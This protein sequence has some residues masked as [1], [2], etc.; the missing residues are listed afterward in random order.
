[1]ADRTWRVLLIDDDD[2]DYVLTRSI[3]AEIKSPCIELEWAPTITEALE[4]LTHHPPDAALVDYHLGE[5]NGVEV[6]RQAI[7]MGTKTPLILLT[8]Y[9]SHAIDL[10]ASQ[11]GFVDYLTKS[12]INATLLERTLRYAIE[13][14]RLVV[15]NQ[16]QRELLQ[17]IFDL[18]P[19]CIA[20]LAGEELVFRLANPGYRA[21]TPHPEIDPTGLS[22][23]EVWPDSDGFQDPKLIREVLVSG[24]P[25]HIDQH[26]RQLPDGRRQYFTLHLQRL[27]W[28]GEKAVMLALWDTTSLVEARKKS[29]QN[30]LDHRRRAEELNAVICSMD[31]A[32]IIY[33]AQLVPQK[34]NP[35]LEEL[36]GYDPVLEGKDGITRRLNF[37][38]PDGKSVQLEDLPEG[39]VLRGER[40]GLVQ[41]HLTDARGRKHDVLIS[42]APLY[43]DDRLWGVVAVWHDI[44]PLVNAEMSLRARENNL[45]QA[46]KLA[47]LGYWTWESTDG[48]ITVSDELSDLFGIPRSKQVNLETY[49][50]AIVPE[51]RERIR[52]AISE[53]WNDDKPFDVEFCFHRPDGELRLAHAVMVTARDEFGRPVTSY[54]VLQD[55]TERHQAEEDARRNAVQIELHHMLMQ[56]REKERLAIARDLHDGPLQEVIAVNFA[57]QEIWDISAGMP[58]RVKVEAIRKSLQKHIRDLRAFCNELRPPALIP[59]G[60][61]KAIRSYVDGFREAHPELTLSLDLM[62]D[63]K[64][65]SEPIRLALFRIFQELLNNIVRHAQASQ[66]QVTLRLRKRSVELDVDDNGRGFIAPHNWLDLARQGHL[67]L[68]GAQERV[69]AVGGSLIIASQ[70]GKG[71]RARAII[72]LGEDHEEVARG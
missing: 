27:D 37:C 32:V 60:L 1:M 41:Y 2:D 39:R 4:K 26:P 15:E 38:S 17:A 24:S 31:D 36:C 64:S 68:V 29:E 11:A 40:T 65:L 63:G 71:T 46:A 22:L 34:A 56:G 7:A 53:A 23:R 28:E 61:E 67:G 45:A 21:I 6:A 33:D 66:V 59:F 49:L 3:L 12:E 72:P 10:E 13:R 62:N 42:A 55:I 52:A 54:G 57:M 58:W 44:T 48:M 51:D 16:Q 47:Q 35:A 5:Q 50:A 19:G 9:G 30:A 70:P 14:Q 43:I 69:E 25:V 20:V 8:G 18:D